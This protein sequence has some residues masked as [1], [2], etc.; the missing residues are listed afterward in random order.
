MEVPAGYD[1]SQAFENPVAQIT[2][3]KLQLHDMELENLSRDHAQEKFELEIISQVQSLGGQVQSLEGQVAALQEALRA[4]EEAQQVVHDGQMEENRCMGERVGA[5]E[6]TVSN[7]Q[8]MS[9]AS[10]RA[11]V[12]RPAHMPGGEVPSTS[13][14]D[15]RTVPLHMLPDE[16]AGCMQ[17][18]MQRT[19]CTHGAWGRVHANLRLFCHAEMEGGEGRRVRNEWPL[20]LRAS[21]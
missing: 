11:A 14:R 15:G 6:L 13:G 5:L 21:R 17:W 2:E 1:S 10:A 9:S 8:R 3:L 12:E 18:E 20:Q 19:N 7:M 16:L 4:M